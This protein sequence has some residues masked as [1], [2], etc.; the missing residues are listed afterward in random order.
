MYRFQRVDEN[1]Q[2]DGAAISPIL[3]DNLQTQKENY[4]TFD[5]VNHLVTEELTEQKEHEVLLNEIMAP[6]NDMFTNSFAIFMFDDNSSESKLIGV[7]SCNLVDGVVSVRNFLKIENLAGSV[8]WDLESEWITVR[9]A[10]MSEH[11]ITSWDEHYKSSECPR[12]TRV[13]DNLSAYD[14]LN[15][16]TIT[17][18]TYPHE[19][20]EN[21]RLMFESFPTPVIV[22]HVP[23]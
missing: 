1:P 22:S 14:G 13:R 23:I 2:L 21:Y 9:N 8:N 7:A 10:F 17:D 16:I 15:T 5:C 4:I 11:N 3:V 20:H 19:N 12:V 18:T 6:T